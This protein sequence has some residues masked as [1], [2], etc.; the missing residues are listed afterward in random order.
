MTEERKDQI[1]KLFLLNKETDIEGLKNL[2][3]QEIIFLIYSAKYFKEK[4]AFL[5]DNFDEKIQ[6]FSNI[7][8]DKIK[9]S[10]ELYI[11]YDKSTN[12]PYIDVSDRIWIFSKE[13]YAKNAEDYFMQQLIMLEIKKI[14]GE[15]IIPTFAKLHMLGIKKIIVDNGEYCTEINRNDILPAP[16]W[17][18]T[19][20]INI[21]VTNPDLQHAMIRFFQLLYSKSNYEGK[22]QT[23]RGL[24][25]HML[26]EVIRG[27]YLI[28]MQLKQEEPSIP[29]GEGIVNLKKDTIMQFASVA[30][31]DDTIWLPTFTDWTEFEKVY[32]KNVLSGN[33]VTYDDLVTLSEKMEGIVINCKGISLRI[34]E[35]NKKMI[36][37]YKKEKNNPKA[38]SV[39]EYIVKKDT[40]VMLG[41]PKEYPSKMI[42]AIKEYMKKQKSIKKSYLRLMIKDNEKSYLIVVDFDGKKEE[43]FKGIADIAIP[44]L[45]GMFIDMM[46]MDDWAKDA[47]KDID[48]FYKKK[49]FG[50]F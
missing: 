36:E 25:N 27:K 40:K 22:E 32:D 16:D 29:S 38:A 21:P 19:P 46:G 11:A 24:E 5:I 17:S 8:S 1:G 34:N 14:N 9:D 42:E 44:Y 13:E 35:K 18:N 6:M 3:I 28:P 30:G 31:E 39:N 23:L 47:V 26:D 15:E 50:L 7:L 49:V 48:P 4:Q 41:E 45:D 12:Y 20:Q 43:L 2:E 33:V 10:E 37:E